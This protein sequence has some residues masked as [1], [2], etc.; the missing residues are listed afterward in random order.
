[1]LTARIIGLATT[2]IGGHTSA[3]VLGIYENRITQQSKILSSLRIV[4]D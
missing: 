2:E 4:P 3:S 1:M